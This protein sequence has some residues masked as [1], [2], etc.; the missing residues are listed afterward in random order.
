[1]RAAW[2]ERARNDALEYAAHIAKDKPSAAAKWLEAIS[3]KADMAALFPASGRMVPEFAREDLREVFAASHRIVYRLL[4]DG[5][6]I[7]RVFHG[8][9]M[10][11][12]S[13]VSEA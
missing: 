2:T 6:E 12:Q 4:E 9:R 3:D 5:V 10:L 7:L 8:A 13:D 11:R 1:M